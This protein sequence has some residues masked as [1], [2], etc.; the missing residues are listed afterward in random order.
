MTRLPILAAIPLA[1]SLTACGEPLDGGD[2]VEIEEGATVTGEQ[3]SSPTGVNPA[4]D[5]ML[6][7]E[8]ESVAT[9]SPAP[10]EGEAATEY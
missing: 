4:E 7:T 9:E 1:L 8:P 5:G 6:Q 2:T 10:M 3:G